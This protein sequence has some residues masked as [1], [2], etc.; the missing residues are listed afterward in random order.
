MRI[1]GKSGMAIRVLS[2]CV[3]D[4]LPAEPT[5]DVGRRV[6]WLCRGLL[7]LLISSTLFGSEHHGYVR[8]GKKLIPGATVTA[9]LDTLKLETTTGE[10]G[11]YSFDIPVNG[12]WMFQ[13]EMFGFAPLREE[14]T[15]VDAVSVLDFD[16]VLQASRTADTPATAPATGFQTVDVKQ[17][18]DSHAQIE[19]RMEAAADPLPMGGSDINEAFL[20]NGSLSGGLQSVQQENFFD[21]M[22]KDP[23]ITKKEKTSK[24]DLA[25]GE[26][27][28]K[29][30]AKKAKKRK[31]LSDTVNSFG[32]S[33]QASQ[34]KGNILYTFRE[35]A[36]DA[37]PGA[38]GASRIVCGALS[39][40]LTFTIT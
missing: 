34:I 20:V 3:C 36:F 33:R 25:P 12:K 14:H 1:P 22:D 4:T 8:S 32:A 11:I 28:A 30:A 18:A 37:S 26:K 5:Y 19:P 17:Q 6:G 13:V 21:Q 9:V 15:L 35:S 16:L 31:S 40:P 2:V 24:S 38:A 27:R 7:F 29:K 10:N 39:A 23:S